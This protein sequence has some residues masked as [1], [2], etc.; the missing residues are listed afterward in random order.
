M[1]CASSLVYVKK[2]KQVPENIL[3]ILC[4]V[5]GSV[6]MPHIVEQEILWV[7][8]THGLMLH[9]VAYNRGGYDPPKKDS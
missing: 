1:A 6:Q 9:W 4:L 3:D 7:Y 5:S 8:S 2:E